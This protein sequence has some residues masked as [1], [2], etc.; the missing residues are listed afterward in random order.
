MEIY[1]ITILLITIVWVMFGIG[2]NALRNRKADEETTE[3]ADTSIE[4]LPADAIGATVVS[5]D[6][7][8]AKCGKHTGNVV[9]YV[10]FLTDEGETKEFAV[11]EEMFQKCTPNATGM[12][13]T[14]DGKFFDFGDGEEIE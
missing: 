14:V 4:L 10:T 6:W 1:P 3:E 2:F 8:I 7:E 13:V 11:S 12:L 5:K 9:Y